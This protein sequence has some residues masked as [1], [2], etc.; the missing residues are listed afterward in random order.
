M[1]QILRSGFKRITQHN[2]LMLV[3]ALIVIFPLLFIYTIQQFIDTSKANI[4]TVLLQKINILH[5]AIA[6]SAKNNLYKDPPTSEFLA[7]QEDLQKLRIVKQEGDSLI[8]V[9][10]LDASKINTIETNTLPYKTSL[11]GNGGTVIFNINIDGKPTTQ[12]IRPLENLNNTTYYIFTQHDF[13]KLYSLLDSRIEKSYFILSFI[14]IFVI[15]LAYWIANQINYR[16][17]FNNSQNKLRERDLFIDALVHEFRAPLTA[18]RGYASLIEESTTGEE[19]SFAG[20]IKDASSR[21]VSLVNDFLEV[22]HIQSGKVKMEL[23]KSDVTLL[24]EKVVL[25]MKPLAD[26]KKLLIKIDK[27]TLPVF[28]TTDSKRLEQVLTNIINNAIK[29]TDKGEIN[30]TLESNIVF[31]TITI[32]D[33]GNGISAEDQ[34][35]MFVP[36]ARFGTG[37]QQDTVIGSGLGL[38]IT[39]QLLE[40]LEGEISVESIKGVGTHV[41]IKLKNKIK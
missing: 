32:A 34:K 9:F 38:W 4:N 41:I 29:Y 20:R 22:A 39:K 10:D 12:A 16:K 30:V 27:P 11:T 7:D 40:Q 31:T 2:Q 35:K 36:F 23:I 15:A 1:I 28:L 14:F 18:I 33:T 17:L 5:D 19:N 24:I 3:I 25:Q 6:F 37:N 21:L 8:I 26:I 13:S